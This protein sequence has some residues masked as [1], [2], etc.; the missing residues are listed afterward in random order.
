M[1]VDNNIFDSAHGNGVDLPFSNAFGNYEPYI[2]TKEEADMLDIIKSH[3][4]EMEREM[5]EYLASVSRC[6]ASCQKEEVAGMAQRL[7]DI[8]YREMLS[9]KKAVEQS[10]QK[11]YI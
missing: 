8:L 5:S 9:I 2:P 7:N 1:M 11:I 6:M 10:C 4:S 3:I